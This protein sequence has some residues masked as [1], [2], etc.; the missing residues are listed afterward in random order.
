LAESKKP[1]YPKPSIDK[2]VG[3]VYSKVT[4]KL[5][6]QGSDHALSFYRQEK[7]S[8]YFYVKNIGFLSS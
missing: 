7:K 6:L 4:I 3:R 8:Q 5:D 2:L 1:I